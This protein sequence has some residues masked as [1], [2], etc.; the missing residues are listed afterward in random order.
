M[1]KIVKNKFFNFLVICLIFMLMTVWIFSGWPRIWQNPAFPPEIQVARATAG[2]VDIGR[3]TDTTTTLIPTTSWAAPNGLFSIEARNDNST[4]TF[5]DSTASVDIGTVDADGYLMVVSFEFE[6]T[7]NGRFNPQGKIVQTSGT[8][9]FVSAFTSG[10][11]RDNSEDRAFVR[12]WAFVDGPSVGADFQFQ[13]KR[14]VDT[15]IG[16][17]VTSSFDIIP[18]Y[19]SDVGVYS[20]TNASLYGGTT[21][22]VVTGFTGTDGTN[23]TR[24]ADVITVAGDNKRY[25][26]FGSWFLEGLGGRTQ[27]I[28]GFDI[29]GIQL[30]SAQGYA[31]AR[32]TSN[33]EVGAMMTHLMETVTADRTIEMTLYRGDG[34]L[35]NQ[36]GA[37]KDGSTP[38]VGQHA[39]VVVELNDSAE[40]FHST[41][42]TGNV[43]LNVTGPVDISIT[44]AV[45]IT[46]N[47]S[48]SF[49]R[50]SDT[51]MDATVAMDALVGANLWAAQEVVSVTSRWTARAHF[52]VNGT[53]DINTKHGN[54]ARNNQGTID[55][56]GWSANLLSFVVLAQNNDI[57]VSI[58][59]LAGGEDG[60]TYEINPDTAGFWGI[61]LDTLEPPPAGLSITAPATAN[62]PD[63]TIGTGSTNTLSNIGDVDFS[64]NSSTWD[65]TVYLEGDFTC[66]SYTISISGSNALNMNSQANGGLEVVI[67]GDNDGNVSAQSA[68]DIIATGSGNQ[69]LV[70]DGGN[71][72]GT[73]T[74]RVKPAL[75]LDIPGDVEACSPYQGTIV[76]TIS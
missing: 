28:G 18:L 55:T 21:P 3:W 40:A 44:R 41:D 60:G 56:F 65:I 35:A 47:D 54:Y 37:D 66:N 48:A 38:T 8:G 30:L 5:T 74:Y 16:G 9:T 23:I 12:T 51:A 52:T 72:G 25:L 11:N 34:V 19:Y 1:A 67:S 43:D 20:S 75:I 36:G 76:F 46:F 58:Q 13:W 64:G 50:A 45:D 63:F 71:P 57:G 39:L 14:D 4:Y 61:N 6:D 32:N 7:S 70:V 33:D 24:S 10:Y 2:D 29:D 68:F 59:E 69:Y 62:F 31:Y 17:T 26:I 22:N 49:T 15:P 42:G 53:E 73:G 27:R